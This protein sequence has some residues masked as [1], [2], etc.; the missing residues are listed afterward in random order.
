[1]LSIET[2][3]YLTFEGVRLYE[4]HELCIRDRNSQQ[5]SGLRGLHLLVTAISEFIDAIDTFTKFRHLPEQ[6]KER[7]FKV[8]KAVR[9]QILL[10]VLN[11]NN[12]ISK[13][14]AS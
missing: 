6:D 3:S 9:K 8:R 14:I 10:T 7:L 1:M 11:T 13:F 4:D 5:S 2:L 12:L